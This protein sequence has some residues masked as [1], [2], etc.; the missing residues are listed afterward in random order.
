LRPG[1]DSG[2][3]GCGARIS[4]ALAVLLGWHPNLQQRQASG[5]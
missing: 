1:H 2:I 4:G 5:S 3:S